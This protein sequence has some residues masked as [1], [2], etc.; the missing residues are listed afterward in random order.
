VLVV[1]IEMKCN[2]FLH[3]CWKRTNYAIF[4]NSAPVNRTVC[5]FEPGTL[6]PLL[7]NS[8]RR[9]PSRQEK[10]R[11]EHGKLFYQ[12]LQHLSWPNESFSH[13]ICHRIH[14]PET[15]FLKI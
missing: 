11:P 12:I 2:F 4:S 14:F 15:E 6:L 3:G 9:R 8:H 5:C 7:V 10:D 1:Q 13:V